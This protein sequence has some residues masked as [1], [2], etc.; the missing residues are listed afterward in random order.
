MLSYQNVETNEVNG[1]VLVG[2][3]LKFNAII[4]NIGNQTVNE[5]GYLTVKYRIQGEGKDETIS[6]DNN[7]LITYLHAGYLGFFQSNKGGDND[8]GIYTFD[9]AGTYTLT[10]SVND[11]NRFP[12]EI[13][14]KNNQNTITI[15]VAEPSSITIR[16]FTANQTEIGRG[17]TVQFA[18]DCSYK[19]M[20]WNKYEIYKED[21]TLYEECGYQYS[22]YRNIMF[23]ETGTYDVRAVIED[24]VTGEIKETEKIRITVTQ[25]DGY[26]LAVVGISFINVE[27]NS[28]GVKPGDQVKLQAIIK[29][30]GNTKAPDNTMMKVTYQVNHEKQ[31]TFYN[32]QFKNRSGLA[33]G[34]STRLNSNKGGISDDGI[35]TLTESGTYTITASVNDGNEFPDEVCGN[36]AKNNKMTITVTVEEP[37]KRIQ[38]ND[39]EADAE[40]V[41]EGDTVA[42]HASVSNVGSA[43]IKLH[44]YGMMGVTYH[45]GFITGTDAGYQ[46][47][48]EGTYYVQATIIDP[49]TSEEVDTG[50]ITVVVKQRQD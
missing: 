49:S 15:K 3:S 17:E 7:T 45:G 18:I 20:F 1:E 2:D 10:V 42:F 28:K 24:L 14:A 12:N 50:F 30:V 29:N 40:E 38:M 31:T 21:G 37:E 6:Y 47:Q 8:D 44:V 19:H 26:D 5:V 48:Q 41:F 27:T 4:K 43:M 34:G 35:Y 33:A 25:T 13:T 32:D 11:D 23:E 36:K 22:L 9:R 39:F 46:F 16:D